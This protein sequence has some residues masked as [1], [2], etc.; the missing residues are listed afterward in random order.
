MSKARALIWLLYLTLAASGAKLCFDDHLYRD[1]LW[2]FF[3]LAQCVFVGR[4]IE[5][6][7][8]NHRPGG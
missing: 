6:R 8:R 7:D 1:G 4:L 3:L 2:C 5:R